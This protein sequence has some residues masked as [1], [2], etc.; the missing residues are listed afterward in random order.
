MTSEWACF[1]SPPDKG[2]ASARRLR[3]R[4]P[5]LPFQNEPI[6]LGFVL[7]CSVLAN[8]H[9]RPLAKPPATPAPT[10][11]L[12]ATPAP[13]ANP[14]KDVPTGQYYTDAI[15]W[16]VKNEVTAGTSATTFSPANPCTRAQI[17]TF[18][19]RDLAK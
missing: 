11:K 13:A 5:I 3:I 12:T 18:L 10:A 17:V 19:Y 4:V 2:A 16:A 6:S 9:G 15:L 8:D 14:F 1:A 7:D